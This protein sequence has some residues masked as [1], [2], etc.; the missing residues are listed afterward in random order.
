M[1]EFNSGSRLTDY[2]IECLCLL[3][4]GEWHDR[5]EIRQKLQFKLISS[6]SNITNRIINPLKKRGLIEQEN[7][8]IKD[9]FKKMKS[10]TRIKT[11]ID[12]CY[13]MDL[14]DLY[15][16]LYNIAVHDRDQYMEPIYKK[17]YRTFD[18]ICLS[19]EMRAGPSVSFSPA[20][21]KLFEIAKKIERYCKTPEKALAAAYEANEE[22][23]KENREWTRL[24]SP[25]RV[26]TRS[27]HDKESLARTEAF[28]AAAKGCSKLP[29]A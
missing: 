29:P 28:L 13:I 5:D 10:F 2:Q 11:D 6:K 18:L 9:G 3:L 8:P 21:H 24:Y 20:E 27:A 19:H 1:P 17:A 26:W 22:L 15:K 23:Q 4:D 7:R 14:R 16:D 25:T 12:L